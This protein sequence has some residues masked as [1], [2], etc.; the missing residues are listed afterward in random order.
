[1]KEL[2]KELD[3]LN[4][5]DAKIKASINA[6]K[7]E[8]TSEQ[9]KLKTLEK[10]I[11]IDEAALAM[12]EGDMASMGGMFEKLKSDEETDRKAFE[13]AQKRL[14][15]VN[16][17][18]AI[19]EEGQATSYQDQLTT[20]KSKIAE[21]NST[22]KKSEMEL[23]YSKQT[24]AKKEKN[25]QLNDSAYLK[26]QD[27]IKNNERE[28]KNLENQLAKIN[29]RDGQI[30]ELQNQHETLAKDC[31]ALQHGIDRQGGG[32]FEFRYS[33]PTQNWDRKRVKGLIANNV[34]LKDPKYS[35]A[36]STIMGG[37][38]RSV[39]TDNDETGKLILEHGKLE[40]RATIIP[41][42]KIQSRSIDRNRVAIAQKLVGKENAIPAIELLEYNKEVEPAIQHVFGTAFVCKD[43][44]TA[45][46]VTFH[47]QIMTKSYTLDGDEMSPDGALAGGAAPAGAPIFDEITN[48][49]NLHNQLNTKKREFEEITRKIGSLKD[50]AGQYRTLKDKH[51]TV[52]LQLNTAQE[53]IQQTAFQQ[54]Q[55]EIDELKNK[56][57]T[58]TKTIE[59]CI[60]TKA[61]NE[62]K[63]K[64]LTAKLADSKGH[65]E[66]EL[67]TAEADLKKAKQKHENS[68]K[69]W[70]KRE[71]EYETLKLEIEELKKTIAEA[72][73][74]AEAMQTKIEELQ[75]KIDEGG[76]S[77]GDLKKRLEELKTQI[78]EQKDAIATQNKELRTKA[79]RKDK[80]LKN[81]QEL[82][83]E[84]KKK[85]NEIVKVKADNTDGFNKI[86]ALEEKY[87][88]IIEDRDH[89]GARNT[90]YDYSKEDPKE[91][92][93]KLAKLQEN[94]EKLSRNI[95]QEAMMLLE[96]EEEHYKKIM[97]RR[98]KV[99][100]DKRKILESIKNMDTKKVE[101]LKTAWEEVN[102]NFGS[103]FSTLLPGAQA[104]LDPPDGV[105]FLKGLEVKVGFNGI[106]K[107]SLTE[108][109]GGQ[110]SLVAL[111]LILAMLKYKPAPLYI[112]DEVDAALD[113]SHTQ[114]IGG[115]LKAHFKNSQFIIV[116][117]KDGM[118]NNANVL[119]RTKFV[120][121]VSGVVRTVNRN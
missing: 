15:A 95:N 44:E 7:E 75:K 18:M 73:Q 43:L 83:L 41:L 61:S 89:F 94:K 25:V 47:N 57:E 32:K 21:A 55:N 12:K 74:Q 96:K 104:K 2:E 65:R 103:I 87:T 63:V 50:V 106:W 112:L 13:D 20:A 80:L 17:G 77:D 4:Q 5:K 93:Q 19:N 37:S 58:L 102:T 36:L 45:K 52:Q 101:N 70:K 76:N 3:E 66:R 10:N 114:N 107:E 117:L 72:K 68:Q 92:G 105:S 30:E 118:F 90:R 60:A 100:D 51:E 113:L 39:I 9:R 69:N 48:M 99:E 109:S 67:K 34:S 85:E 98:H 42:N 120:D 59:E 29:Y 1:M 116:S 108:L 84:I 121:G 111:S 46:A 49:K 16:M 81:N 71:Q 56:I 97:E 110:R 53:R 14:E 91:A 26:D 119:F 79:H 8:I 38:W 64:D 22:I 88:W 28:L 78:K 40:Q 27:V 82:E 62:E 24:L 54:D 115:M 35:R 31:R 86:R 6:T 23:K 11:K 33:D